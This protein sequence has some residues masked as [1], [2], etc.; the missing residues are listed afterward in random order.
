MFI[1]YK[2]SPFPL[3]KGLFAFAKAQI[4]TLSKKEKKMSYDGGYLERYEDVGVICEGCG[5]E[6][7]FRIFLEQCERCRAF[8]RMVEFKK[9]EE[10]GGEL[11]IPSGA[12]A[13]AGYS[14]TG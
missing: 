6:T 4:S 14:E 8:R 1:L 9:C 3:G 13:C 7:R 12:C 11:Y 2:P 10:C 5:H